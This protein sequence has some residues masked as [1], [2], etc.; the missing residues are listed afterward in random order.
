MQITRFMIRPFSGECRSR[1]REKVIENAKGGKPPD[2]A[3]PYLN[4]AFLGGLMFDRLCAAQIPQG[5][6]RSP[7]LEGVI[8]RER[9]PVRSFFMGI[10]GARRS[11]SSSD[12]SMRQCFPG[13]HLFV[14]AKNCALWGNPPGERLREGRRR[15]YDGNSFPFRGSRGVFLVAHLEWNLNIAAISRTIHGR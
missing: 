15:N 8:A 5:E 9:V 6:G 3:T 11:L 2:T 14:Q 12:I 1:N 10:T 4:F 7:F 13:T